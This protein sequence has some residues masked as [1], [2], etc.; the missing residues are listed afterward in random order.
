MGDG[1]LIARIPNMRGGYLDVTRHGDRLIIGARELD[2]DGV[3]QLQVALDRAVA[4]IREAGG[5]A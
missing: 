1:E 5:H 2:L 4:R 3:G